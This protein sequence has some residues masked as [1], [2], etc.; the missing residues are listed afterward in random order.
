MPGAIAAGSLRIKALAVVTIITNIPQAQD[1]K[2]YQDQIDARSIHENHL[3]VPSDIRSQEW[4]IF[5]QIT[6]TNVL[7]AKSSA[8]YTNKACSR[9][10]FDDVLVFDA[11]PSLRC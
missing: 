7:R 2:D 9:P 1:Y 8:G 10:N 11:V 3:S 6:D 4:Q 5:L